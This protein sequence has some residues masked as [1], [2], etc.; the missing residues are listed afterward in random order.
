MVWPLQYKWIVVI[1][2]RLFRWSRPRPLQVD[3]FSFG[4]LDQQRH[5]F[6]KAILYISRVSNL[7]PKYQ[8]STYTRYSLTY[9]HKPVAVCI[10]LYVYHCSMK[11]IRIRTLITGENL[12]RTILANLPGELYQNIPL[13][14]S[15]DPLRLSVKCKLNAIKLVLSI[16]FTS[17]NPQRSHM[18]FGNQRVPH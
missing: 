2:E 4:W 17:E 10:P 12:I 18:Q 14:L 6:P 5:T 13:R 8:W 1:V 11:Y 16:T 7:M 3:V 15:I 9:L